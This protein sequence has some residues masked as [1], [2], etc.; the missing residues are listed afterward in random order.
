VLDFSLKAFIFIGEIW[1][2][3]C[4][5][6]GNTFVFRYCIVAHNPPKNVTN[7]LYHGPTA[8]THTHAHTL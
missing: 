4:V 5:F 2:L 8:H 3:E 7:L 1:I 6:F